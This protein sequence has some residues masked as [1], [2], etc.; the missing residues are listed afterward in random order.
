MA[1]DQF[2][3]GVANSI[4]PA[5][6]VALI[7]IWLIAYIILPFISIEV[8]ACAPTERTCANDGVAPEP[9]VGVAQYALPEASEVRTYP[10]ACLPSTIF[11]P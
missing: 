10:D 3:A 2:T 1:L 8:L 6:Y 11:S 5:P 4:Y 9:P 7:P